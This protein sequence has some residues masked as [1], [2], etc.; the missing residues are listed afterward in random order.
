MPSRL[1]HWFA[2]PQLLWMLAGLPALGLLA[3]W[4]RRR[5]RRAMALLGGGPALAATLTRDRQ[6]APWLFLSLW[7]GLSLLAV[8]AAGPQWGR[9]WSQSATV[10]R[11]LVVVLDMSRSMLAESKSRLVRAKEAILDLGETVRKRGGH[12][13]GLVV[14]AGRARL[15]CPLTH[16][17]SHFRQTVEGFD[18]EHLDPALWAEENAAS[19]TRIG[20]GLL[21]AVGAHTE[22]AAGVQDIVL[23]SDGDDPAGDEEWREG[24][25]AARERKIPIYTVGVGDP[26]RPSPI[27]FD[28]DVLFHDG[29]RVRSKLEEKPLREIARET[30]ARYIPL[31]TMEYP[32]GELYLT[33]IAA[34]GEREH[35]VDALP[36]YQQRAIWFLLPATGLLFASFF[37]GE[38][39]RARP[40][41][42][43][44]QEQVQGGAS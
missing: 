25:D 17:Y 43:Q 27:P 1:D 22:E 34:G 30:E 32:L 5:R 40:L 44:F 15:V 4:A 7:I 2:H 39:R 6:R 37:L 13:I 10:G 38:G 12:R 18:E 11:D 21:L 28:N 14:F 9:D 16:D 42:Q 19:G 3:L 24:I 26:E 29:D 41:A 35:G 33:W 20:A 36:V 31:R 23:V 8:G